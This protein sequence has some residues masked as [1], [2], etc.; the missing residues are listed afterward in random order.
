MTVN[1]MENMITNFEDILLVYPEPVLKNESEDSFTHSFHASY[2][3]KYSHLELPYVLFNPIDIEII[4]LNES[5]GDNG[6]WWDIKIGKLKNGI[7]FIQ[8]DHNDY[9]FSGTTFMFSEDVTDF[10]YFALDDNEREM[11]TMLL[12]LVEK[13]KLENVV[14]DNNQSHKIKI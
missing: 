14:I 12:P 8:S 7:F 2:T 1:L 13:E 3:T 9:T 10:Y 6:D 11:A 5:G 4:Y